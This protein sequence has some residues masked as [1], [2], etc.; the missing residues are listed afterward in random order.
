MQISVLIKMK[1]MEVINN[2]DIID[3]VNGWGSTPNNQNVNYLGLNVKMKPST[4]INLAATLSEPTSVTLIQNHLSDGG[5]IG[6]PFLIIDLPSEW[7]DNDFTEIA[8][9]KGHEG[10]N[11]MI[12]IKNLYGDIPIETHLFF[13]NGIR[14]RHLTSNI[15]TN[16]QNA[17]QKERSTTIV[18]NNLF[19]T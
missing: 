9:V 7:E 11:R 6:A 18:K 5:K 16:L 2:I 14:N 15:I 8:K 1:I 19:N 13:R 12:V 10:R 4:F 3:N 17:M